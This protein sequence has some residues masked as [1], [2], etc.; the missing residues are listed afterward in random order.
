MRRTITPKNLGYDE[1]L[2]VQHRKRKTKA[3][4]RLFTV[5]R[6]CEAMPG[7]WIEMEVMVPHPTFDSPIPC[8]FL[9]MQNATGKLWQRFEKVDDLKGFLNLNE[10]DLTALNSALQKARAIAE[11]LKEAQK[12]AQKV[13][14][15]SEN[16]ITRESEIE[17]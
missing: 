4:Q 5:K 13:A 17:L 12:I 9:L 3:L 6:R 7:F 1:V 2:V 11:N 8:A 15:L 14:Y 16:Q 10:Q